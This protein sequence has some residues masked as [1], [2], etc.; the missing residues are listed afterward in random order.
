MKLAM[1]R[2]NLWDKLPRPLKRMAGGMLGI[3][4]PRYLLGRRFQENLLFARQAQ[5]WPAEQAREYQLSRVRAI[6]T[7]AYEKT[8]F[9]RRFFD[10]AGVDPRGLKSL[11]DLRPLPT[12]SKDTLRQSLQEMC[13]RPVDGGD[14]DYVST[15]GT[16]GVPLSFY[17]GR[18]RS[19][20]EYA[21][22]IASWERAGYRLGMPMAVLRGRLVQP[23]S[24][25]LYH[26]FDP[27]LRHH[28][29]SS[30]HM[31][32]E[33]LA[34]YLAHIAT[35]G[36]CYL[37]VY[38]SAVARL[39]HHIRRSGA[40]SPANILGIVAESEIVYTSQRQMVQQTFGC[41]YFS[42]YGHTEKLVLAAE[43]EQSADYHVWPTYGHCELLDEQGQSVTTP[44]GR[45]EIVATGFINT[46]V[47]FIRYRTGDYATY[48]AD[49]C[50]ACGR[51]QMIL[52][53]IRG[54][55][56]Q[57]VLVAADGSSI[58]WVGVNMHDDTF[59]RVRQFQFYQDRPGQAVLR[60]VPAEG[61]DDSDCRKMLRNLGVKL[62]GRVRFTVEVVGAIALSSRGKAIYVDQ[63]IPGT[64]LSASGDLGEDE[65][66]EVSRPTDRV[67]DR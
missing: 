66:E 36:P 7:L 64:M 45:G 15:G 57:E 9:Y 53:R 41:P 31:S 61:F 18:Q 38:P 35:I 28:Y 46:V 23:D 47:P 4:P 17:I 11:E 2:K 13:A 59:D 25:G 51:Q 54:H 22:L 20:F 67:P 19:A 50:A 21:Y 33:N 26:E 3:V 10:G 12:T 43:C 58:S 14:V 42:S 16:S 65:V 27:L 34:R 6:C 39:A 30:F 1:S 8:A 48:V 60:V 40:R 55:R 32:E 56:T 37:H 29:Y 49:S 63:R 62:A 24:R 44:G 5:W 52:R